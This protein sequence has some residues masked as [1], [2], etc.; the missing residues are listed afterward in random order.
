MS[1]II[2][3]SCGN[4]LAE[5]ALFCNM[6]GTNV[7]KDIPSTEQRTASVEPTSH[8]TKK[9][10]KKEKKVKRKKGGKI[11]KITTIVILLSLVSIFAYLFLSREV[12]FDPY[13]D[14]EITYSGYDDYGTAEILNT[15]EII[16]ENIKNQK[17]SFI[18]IYKNKLNE[19]LNKGTYTFEVEKAN[20]E[21]I[22]SV[23]IDNED[24]SEDINNYLEKLSNGDKVTITYSLPENTAKLWNVIITDDTYEA[25]VVGLNPSFSDKNQLSSDKYSDIA[26]KSLDIAISHVSKD[27][28]IESYL[29]PELLGQYMV[30]D[31]QINKGVISAFLYNDPT[32]KFPLVIS[33][34]T[35]VYYEEDDFTYEVADTEEMVL[36]SFSEFFKNDHI[37]DV[38]NGNGKEY[39]SSYLDSSPSNN[40]SN[41]VSI[42]STFKPSNFYNVDDQFVP[43]ASSENQFIFEVGEG[44][45]NSLYDYSV[46]T[47]WV[48]R[49]GTYDKIHYEL[50]FDVSTRPVAGFKII[51]GKAMGT[52]NY[53]ISTKPKEIT[54]ELRQIDGSVKKYKANIANNPDWQEFYFNEI[55]KATSVDFYID[56]VYQGSDSNVSIS[57]LILLKAEDSNK[58]TYGD[59]GYIIPES[60]SRKLTYSD[61]RYLSP[62]ELKLARN[63]IYARHGR[64]FNSEELQSHFNNQ[65]WYFPS[66]PLGTEPN[67][68]DIELYNAEFIREYE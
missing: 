15:E 20:N 11:F 34:R 45:N 51:P 68:S 57:E 40:I 22:E 23:S 30:E 28:N 47:S 8:N 24:G 67:I 64:R 60:S 14:I 27:G 35:N 58:S 39:Y 61:I 25:E 55:V 66:L 43:R 29:Y 2:C 42:M 7:V 36:P 46:D 18:E 16:E 1:Q 17:F 21:D 41:N 49:N 38:I 54:V 63:E 19:A 44:M 50:V 10:I 52:E 56:S 48:S 33:V 26:D 59:S 31:E 65:D 32:S 12:E 37:V 5:D 4:S 3:K 62:E 13:L 53:R 6:C 9:N